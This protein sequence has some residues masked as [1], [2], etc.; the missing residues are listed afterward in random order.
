MIQPSDNKLTK[1]DLELL[2]GDA[3]VGE[4]VHCKS[5]ARLLAHR[6]RLR[7]KLRL[8]HLDLHGPCDMEVIELLKEG[9]S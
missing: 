8:L 7:E 4:R 5:L 2:R 1:G 3:E 9:E 6:D